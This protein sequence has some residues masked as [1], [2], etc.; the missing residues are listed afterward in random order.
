MEGYNAQVRQL[1]TNWVTQRSTDSFTPLS[2]PYTFYDTDLFWSLNE[3][4]NIYILD[5]KLN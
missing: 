4:S 2:D 5:Y 1:T 3:I